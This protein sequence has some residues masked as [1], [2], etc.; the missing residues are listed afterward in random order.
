[1]AQDFE[2][3]QKREDCRNLVLFIHGFTGDA[4]KTWMN[5]NGYSFPKLLLND[6]TI[7][8][9]FDIASYNYFTELLNLFA[10]VK[11]K[12]RWLRDLIWKKT[13][14]K[15]RNLNIDE[16]S[17]N[18]SSHFRFTLEQYD[19]IYVIAHSMGG[20]ITK[21]LIKNELNQNNFTKVKFFISL[22]VPHQGASMSV[23]GNLISSNLQISNLNPV[24][25]FI[26][27]LNQNWVYLDSKPTTKYFYGSYDNV[28]TKYSAVAIDKIEKDI[29]AVPEDHTTI[30]KPEN[31]NSIV[32]QSVIQ[33][34]KEQLKNEKLDSVGFQKLPDIENS[35]LDKEIFVLKLIIADIASESQD[36]AKELFYNAE[37]VRKLFNSRHDKEQFE[38]LFT[39]IRQIYKDSYDKFLAD[40]TVNSGMLLSEVHTKITEQDSLLLKSLIPSLQNFHKKGML[41]QLANDQSN[42]IWWCKEKQLD[43][44]N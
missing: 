6:S 40:K 2:F 16:L 27:E 39:N 43:K 22:A 26:N 30:C 8:D 41:H 18:L 35:D 36:N 1:M 37:F 42:D 31:D 33:L 10:D 38:K 19:N 44:E 32:Y 9:N 3:Y 5:A 15:E 20:L 11:E 17:N 24:E 21:N 4:E 13:H 23:L 34:I 29:I 7:T 28:V 25:H 14:K 12:A